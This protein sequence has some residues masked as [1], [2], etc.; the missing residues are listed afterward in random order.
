MAT[1][2]EQAAES[3]LGAF[4]HSLPLSFSQ[5]TVARLTSL[6]PIG[7]THTFLKGLQLFSR[8]TKAM[9]SKSRRF[10]TDKTVGEAAAALQAVVPENHFGVM[11]VHN[12][13]EAMAKKGV[14]FARECLTDQIEQRS[15]PSIQAPDQNRIYLTSPRQGE[16]CE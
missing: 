14:E 10:T 1:L 3:S 7:C 2:V 4:F 6:G 13:K 12:L 9:G 8:M 11:Q 5:D 15:P 16:T